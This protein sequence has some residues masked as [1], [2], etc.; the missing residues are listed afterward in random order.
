MSK[1]EKVCQQCQKVWYFSLRNGLRY[2]EKTGRGKYCSR[3]CYH[4]SR[5]GQRVS[6]ATEFKPGP[7]ERRAEVFETCECGKEFATSNARL[8]DDRGKYCSKDCAYKYR[9]LPSGSN[10]HNWKGEG[11]GYSAIHSWIARIMGK[12][13]YCERCSS[14]KRPTN[15]YHWA[16]M[17]GNYERNVWDWQRLC[18]KCHKNF[19]VRRLACAA[20]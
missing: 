17:S 7:R 20:Q 4:E 2:S 16:N 10:H 18:A 11:V 12:P 9:T 5:K 3:E 13:K 15:Q 8:D 6:P 14:S 1:I 19:D